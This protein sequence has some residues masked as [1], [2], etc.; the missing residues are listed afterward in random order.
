[1]L[2]FVEV[3][4][5]QSYKDLLYSK[6]LSFKFGLPKSIHC[7]VLFDSGFILMFQNI[8]PALVF[9]EPKRLEIFK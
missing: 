2:K 3:F 1:M 7:E 4:L 9:I 6:I 5:L 8:K